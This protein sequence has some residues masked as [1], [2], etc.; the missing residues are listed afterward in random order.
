MKS[1]TVLSVQYLRATA[2]LMV[3]FHHAREQFPGFQAVFPTTAGA[4]GVDLFFVISG[5]VMVV[6]SAA[7]P[8]TASEFLEMRIARIVPIYW[9][10]TAVTAALLLT[11]PM[12]FRVNEFTI[13]HF[14]LSLFFV[15]HVAPG[16]VDS[17]SPMVKL[18]WSLDYEMFFYVIFA[19]AIKVSPAYRVPMAAGLLI[20][21]MAVGQADSFGSAALLFYSDN[22]VL[23][24]VFG[25]LIGVAFVRSDLAAIR[26]HFAIALIV[27]GF[28][29]IF[30]GD[31][32]YP[33]MPR[34]LVFGLPAA[35]IV[36]ASVALEKRGAVGFFR[37]PLLIGDASYS[38]YLVHLFPI[39][40]LRFLLPRLGFAT[41]GV[42]TTLLFVSVCL[43]VGAA[44]GIL[45]YRLLERP[46]S[47]GLRVALERRVAHRGVA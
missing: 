32:V 40:V 30:Y 31:A 1:G 9:F 16:T 7:K 10:Y 46:L 2:A 24:F 47:G 25:M 18:G 15:P 13:P 34:A 12:F 44:A 37:L 8:R 4:A 19:L 14:L 29:A 42:W 45:S 26:I 33:H 22:I 6:V 35:A 21:V 5:F 23:E 17:L 38:I 43:V 39:V 20:V 3:V 27:A 36:L 41:E 28:L 11:L